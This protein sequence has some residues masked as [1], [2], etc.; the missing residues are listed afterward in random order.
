MCAHRGNKFQ[1]FSTSAAMIM[2]GNM[3]DVTAI[4]IQNAW[5]H[6]KDLNKKRRHASSTLSSTSPRRIKNQ[7]KS[8]HRKKKGRKGH[9]DLTETSF[10]IFSRHFIYL[11]HLTNYMAYHRVILLLHFMCHILCVIFYPYLIFIQEI[12]HQTFSTH[13]NLLDPHTLPVPPPTPPS[14]AHAHTHTHTHT[15]SLTHTPYNYDLESKFGF[16]N[17][18]KICK[19]VKVHT[20]GST[21]VN[22]KFQDQ[23]TQKSWSCGLQVVICVF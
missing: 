8:K 10:L 21:S 11:C 23:G 16:A 12:I 7:V 9:G 20:Q 14:T 5:K 1:F 19:I 6:F 15:H 13:F 2:M 4:Q 18:Q 22:D 3:T 17:K